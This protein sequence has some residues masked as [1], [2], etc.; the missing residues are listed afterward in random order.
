MSLSSSKLRLRLSGWSLFR[1]ALFRARLEAQRLLADAPADDLFQA[2]KG[3]A[4]DEQ[5]VGRIHRGEFLVRMLASALRRHIGDRAFEDLQ[6]RLLHAFARNIARD[7]RVLVFPS[8]LVDFIDI[9]DAGLGASYIAVG[10]LQQ[11]EDDV[12]NVLADVAGFGQ[13]G[14]VHDGEGHIQHAGQ[15]LRQQ[16]F[17]G[18]RGTDQHD[19]RLGQF[20][21]VAG[22]LAIHVD[23]LVVVVNRHRQLLLGLLLADYVF[24][25]EALYFLRLG[26]LIG[27]G[28]GGRRRAVVFQDGIADRHALV[29]NIGPGIIA[30]G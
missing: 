30:G 12:L 24:V 21:A 18:S 5:N 28:G 9:D 13:R 17:A 8:D 20:D 22:A 25:E 16:G 1:L 6:Q 14:G 10:R 19:V 3:A 4:A 26:Q 23:A 11:L 15:G 2:D 27:G 7:G 29:A